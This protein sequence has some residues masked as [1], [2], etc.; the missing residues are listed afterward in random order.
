MKNNNDKFTLLMRNSKKKLFAVFLF[1]MV[2]NVSAQ[3]YNV[4]GSA[5]VMANPNCYRLTNTT[6]QGGAVWNI[7]MINLTQPFDITLTLNFGSNPGTS[8]VGTNCGA[9]GMSFIL[10]PLS[11]GVVGVGGLVGFGGITPSLGVIMDDFWGNA[12]DPPYHHISINKNGDPSHNVY[13]PAGVCP[14]SGTLTTLNANELATYCSASGFP[15]NIT[16][17]LDHLFRFKW[18]PT[19]TGVGT[20]QVWF[21]NATTLPSSPTISYSGNIVSNIFGGNPNVY[22]GVGGSTGACW[23]IQTVCMTTA[24]NFS[25]P[26]S[27]CAGDTVHFTNNSISGLPIQVWSWDFGDGTYSSDTNAKHVFNN[28]GVYSVNLAIFNSGGFFSTMTHTVTINPKPTVQVNDTSVCKGDTAV[29]TASGATTYA[30]NNGLTAGAIKKVAPL[31]TT[32]YIV[33]GTNSFGCI[34]KDTALVTINPNPIITVTSDSICIGDS[35]IITAFGG[36]S[37]HWTPTG[38]YTNPLIISPLVTT[39]YKVIGTNTFGCKDSTT[40]KVVVNPNPIIHVTND[41]ICLNTIAT[42]TA[43]GAQTYVWGNNLS[44]SNP[45][46]VSP[47]VTTTYIV[48]GTDINNCIGKDSGK[49][50]VNL[51]PV[52]TVDSADICAGLTATLTVSGGNN[53]AYYWLNDNSTF[54]PYHASPAVTTVYTV[55]ATDIHGCKDTASGLITVHP[56]PVPNFSPNPTIVTTDAPNVVFTD[57]STFAYS[58]LWNFGDPTSSNDTSTIQYPNHSYNTSGE[59]NIWLVVTSDFGCMDSTYRKV[60]VQMPNS[61][62]I[63]NSLITSNS[64]PDVCIFKPKGTGIDLTKYQMIIFDRWGKEIFSTTDFEQGWNGKM[65]NVGDFLSNGVYVYYIK[66]KEIYGQYRERTGSVTLIR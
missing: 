59:Y 21:G 8:S 41:T 47:I 42:L 26:T 17:G 48:V 19:I 62:Y 58:W 32:S 66:Y 53:L 33:T 34:N 2:L 10:Q 56:K 63:P 24:S 50:F 15:A 65:N 7:Y 44:T 13:T 23:N 45:F 14:P 27:A 20:I 61:F 6:S 5:V 46:H 18:T 22:W 55:V 28:P 52:I 39:L 36:I 11:T 35:A 64:N 16:D 60:L 12:T 40:T 51:P 37:Y 4:S 29:L 3:Q 54:N 30:W 1:L 31:V 25:S 38:S 49:V 43:S 9:D 57:Q